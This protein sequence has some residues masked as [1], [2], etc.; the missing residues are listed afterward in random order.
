MESTLHT[1]ALVTDAQTSTSKATTI[2]V[3]L[4]GGDQHALALSYVFWRR[5]EAGGL[6]ERC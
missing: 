6:R 4:G 3:E 5:I 1:P 2:I